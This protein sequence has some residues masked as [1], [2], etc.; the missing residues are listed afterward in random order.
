MADYECYSI[1]ITRTYGKNEFKED[2]KAMMNKVAANCG[3]GLMFLFSDMQIVKESFLEDINNILNTGEVPNLFAQDEA[4]QIVSACRP[5]AKAAG[6]ETRDGIWQFFVQTVRENLHIALAFSPIGEGFRA[7]C[8]QFPSLINCTSIDWYSPWPV[9]ALYSVA[10][11]KYAAMPADLGIADL[12]PQLSRMSGFM[13]ATA[14]DSAEN[15]FDKLR[16]RTYMTPTSYLELLNLFSKLLEQKKGELQTKLHRYTV[17]SKTL[18][19]TQGVVDQLKK[20][21]TK[22]QP[23][24]ET[25]KVDTAS[26]MVKVEADQKIAEEKSKACAIDEAAAT[27]AATV[28]TA[29]QD[30]CQADLDLALPEFNAAIKSLDQ[31]DKK[32]ITEVKSFAKPPPLVEVVLSA[33][34]LLMGA[35]ENWDDA[36]KLMNDSNFLQNL[37]NYDKEA[38]AVNQ[39]LTNKLQKYMKRDDFNAESCSKVSKAATT[40]CCWVRAMDIYSRVAREIEPKKE[41]LKG[42]QASLADAQEKLAIKKAEL[43]LV[44]DNVAELQANLQAAK[45]KSEQLEAQAQDCV[46]KLE[47]AEKLLAGLG[48]ESV[49]WKKASGI[50]ENSLKFVIGNILMAGGFISYTGPFTSEFRKELVAGWATEA[51]RVDLTTDPSW[52]IADVLVDPAEVRGWNI[53]GLPP[54]DL[55]VENGIMVTRGGRWPLMIDPQGQANRWIRRMGKDKGVIVMKFSDVDEK[56]GNPIYLRKLEAGIRNGNPVLLEN[57][58]EVLDP[59]IEPVLS[60]A[61]VKRGNQLVLRLGDT[62]VPYDEAFN[63][64]ITTKMANP[65]YLPE[66]CIKVTVINF[67]VTLLGLEDQFVSDVVANEN[68]ELAAKRAELVV[69]IANDKKEMDDLEQLILKLLADAAGD[70]LKD[71]SLIVTLDQSKK[72]GDECKERTDIAEKAMVEIEVVTETLRPVATRS[73]ILYFVLADLGKIDPMYQY[74][75]EYFVGLFQARLRD[76]EQSEDILKRIRILLD[77]ITRFIYLNICRG[78]FEDHKMLFSFLISVQILRLEKHAQYIKRTPI[79]MKEWL[80]FLRGVE[81]GKG[82]IPDARE[83]GLEAPP[84]ILPVTWSKLDVLERFSCV[85]GDSSLQGLCASIHKGGEWEKFIGNDGI[86]NLPLPCGWSEKLTPFQEM[87]V[88]KSCRENLATLVARSFIAAELGEFFTISPPF[89]LTGAFDDS[90]ST[91]PLIFVLSSGADPTEYLLALARE[92]GYSERLHFISLGQGQ[93]PIAEKLV[94]FGWETGD[95]VCLQNCHL[96]NS[97]MP[98]LEQIQESQDPQKIN[99]EYRLWLTSMPSPTFPV[100]V[101]QAGVKITNEPPKGLR[102]NL[103]RTFQDINED[104]YEGCAAKPMEYKKMLYGLAI[105]HAV[106]LERRK[107]GPI[108]WNIPYE[109]M[110]SD[111]QVSRQ[112]VRLYLI[113]Q[114]QVPWVT[115]QYLISEVNYGGRVTDDKDVRLIAAVLKGYFSPK[116]FKDDFCFA[117][118][119]DYT[120]PKVG[121]LEECRSHVGNLPMDEDPR[122]FGLHPNALITAQFNQARKFLDTVISVQPRIAS[123]GTGKKPEEIVSEMADDFFKAIPDATKPKKGVVHPETY[124]EIKGGGIVSIGVFHGQ[125]Y[126]RT[127]TMISVIKKS[128]TM[129]GKAIKGIVLMSADMEGMYNAFLVQ[130]VPGN[131]AKVAYP[132]MKPL[133]SWVADFIQRIGFM[134]RW[135]T[136]GPPSS[137]WIAS[138]FFP[139]GFMTAALQLHARKTKIPIDELDFHPAPSN[140]TEVEK[141]KG[142]PDVGVNIHGLFLQGC[143]WHFSEKRLRESDK[144]VLFVGMPIIQLVPEKASEIPKLIASGNLYQC[145]MYKTS[146]R[147]G[148]L[149]TTGHSTNFVK[150]FAVGQLEEDPSHWTARGVAMLCMLDD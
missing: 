18:I 116:I 41:K 128:L 117:E 4:E 148:T 108:G 75:L 87:L 50:L 35:K 58:E 127:M 70:V 76:S 115:L 29:I 49:R 39:K 139:Q 11:R 80:V 12:V 37:K 63:L 86:N 124:K 146:E 34:C 46:V 77:D 98:K 6:K 8:R 57:V 101:L 113:S 100:P 138:F 60:K 103:G 134:V 3:K 64:N 94:K 65:H 17:G 105:F 36:K 130:K 73:S 25:A 132:C 147:K 114:D 21:L 68:P 136:G 107:F 59:A 111:F 69:Q 1:E 110:D 83:D 78:L 71:D 20:D 133:N 122:I 149:S 13:H 42:A 43:K 112:Q 67:T 119:A 30:D 40:L 84:W 125:E 92:K 99:E 82:A 48:N 51:K 145:P 22:M 55:S 120:I 26:L 137:F 45:R 143:G 96:A 89:D 91:S 97:W 142:P 27:E 126:D 2:L 24:I 90:T 95:W 109:W 7:R 31:L 141:L 32:D 129:L 131:W 106:I 14:K 81:A 102:A 47:R 19:D 85:D 118:L 61:I 150:Y 9:D 74:S 53:H 54:D 88:K 123:G 93:G 10:E 52:N 44:L 140:E 56:T 33:V 38:L 72:T 104:I 79:D 28:A 135:L 16:R 144:G 15:F 121:T 23:E 62:D 5:A 66:I